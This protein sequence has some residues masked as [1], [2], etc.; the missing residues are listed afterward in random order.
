[1][2]KRTKGKW[3]KKEREAHV[4]REKKECREGAGD[5]TKMHG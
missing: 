3:E 5:G 4:G 1:M 2:E